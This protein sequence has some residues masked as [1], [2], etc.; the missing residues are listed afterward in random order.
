MTTDNFTD[1]A[2]WQA[3]EEL[4]AYLGTEEA[5]YGFR[6]GFARGAEWARTHLAAQ[7]PSDGEVM[8]AMTAYEGHPD[9]VSAWRAALSVAW[10]AR[11]ARRGEEKQ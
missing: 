6:D 11:A 1:T 4:E 2:A 8:A 10:S 3:E 5:A 7:E 9:R